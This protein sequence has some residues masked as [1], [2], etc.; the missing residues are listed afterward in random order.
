MV[1]LALVW[2][3]VFSTLPLVGG[4][5][6]LSCL[7]V[8]AWLRSRERSPG[9]AGMLLG[10]RLL[11]ILGITALL[12]GPSREL[13]SRSS[14]EPLKLN[15]LLDT[16]QS[17]LVE[18]C[19]TTSR[20]AH[21]VRQVLSPNQLAALENDFEITLQGFDTGLHPLSLAA[22]RERPEEHAQGRDTRLS[23][24]V[25]A[26]LN[27]TTGQGQ[28]LLVVSDGRDTT[29]ESV[30]SAGGVAASRGIPIFTVALGGASTTADAA[31][32]AVPMQDSMLPNE[33]GGL[34]VRVYQSGLDGANGILRIRQGGEEQQIPIEFGT[35]KV[36]ELQATIPGRPPGQYEYDVSLDP[37]NAETELA[38]NQQ[39][40]F[41][42]VMEKRIRVLVLEGQPFWDTKFLAQSLRKDEQIEIVQLTQV[43]ERKRETLVTRDSGASLRLP[44]TDEAWSS[45]DV[46]IVGRGL[47]HLL[48][49]AGAQ[50]MRRYVEGGGQLVL[51]RGRPYNPESAQG[52]AV[53]EA[54]RPL[55]PV[56]WGEETLSNATLELA[57]SGRTSSW[58]NLSKMPVN[59]EEMLPRL[60]PLET[61]QQAVS[62]KPA[63]IV[64][65]TAHDPRGGDATE[66]PAIVRANVGR[67]GV[68]AI[69][70]EG[71]WRWSL[72]T[73]DLQDMRGFYD[74][75][76][77]NLVRWMALG[78]DFAPGQQ[79]SLQLSRRSVRLGDELTIDVVYRFAPDGAASPQIQILKPDR[80]LED[81]A[82]H[83]MAGPHPR[84]RAKWTPESPGTHR[85]IALTPGMTP[86]QLELPFIVYDVNIE[87]LQTSADPLALRILSDLSG[88]AAFDAIDGAAMDQLTAALARHRRALDAPPQI[89][90]VWDRMSLML[91]L[92][93]WLSCEWLL[94]RIAG[95][96]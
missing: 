46:V 42:E 31:L 85:V 51:A 87:R 59:P 55:E 91:L 53:Q 44:E 40:V 10:M 64:L 11:A 52:R 81:V 45:Y 77:S 49:A 5:V 92:L 19:G 56:V 37:L 62:V 50:R 6:V 65:S 14:S 70:G 76:W 60:P 27:R 25:I 17:M 67:G 94:R 86:P 82:V 63:T 96:W 83:R 79:T 89:E 35:Q 47:E 16:S 32:L 61:L 84:Y 41:I 38:N 1:T 54:L 73:P 66:R 75:F 71:T 28:A 34:L 13:A 43:G 9:W 8:F 80:Q 69:L 12:F 48:D 21:A 68:V 88:G 93:G 95:L 18:D 24:S 7:A 4:A 15:I 78:G 23:E 39:R 72:L 26:A 36:V 90:Y 20:I 74:L 3:P 30:Q 58:M 33:A 2:R 22:V 57:G 29:G